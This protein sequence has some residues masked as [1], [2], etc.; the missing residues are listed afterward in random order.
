MERFILAR[1]QTAWAA[2]QVKNSWNLSSA[3]PRQ[4]GQSETSMM[5]LCRRVALVLRWSSW[6]SHPNTLTLLGTLIPSQSGEGLCM[7]LW[8]RKECRQSLFWCLH[9]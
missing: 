9:R 5:S 8:C 7:L 3:T 2:W 1:C 6:T 4:R